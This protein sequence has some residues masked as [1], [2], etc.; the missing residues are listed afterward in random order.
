MEGYWK[1]ELLPILCQISLPWQKVSRGRIC[2][3][4]VNSLTLKT[5]CLVQE[6]WRYF[7]CNLLRGRQTR[8]WWVKSAV[9][10]L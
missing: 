8:D 2:L 3:T 5:P 10:C 6:S 1:A 7:L 9:F 4:S